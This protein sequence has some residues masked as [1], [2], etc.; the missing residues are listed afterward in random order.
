MAIAAGDAELRAGL[1]ETRRLLAELSSRA[2]GF[3][4]TLGR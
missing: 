4:R 2:P 1:A 3:L